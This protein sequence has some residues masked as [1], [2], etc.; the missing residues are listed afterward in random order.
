MKES[1]SAKGRPQLPFYLTITYPSALVS[2]SCYHHQIPVLYSV[3]LTATV[4]STR[5]VVPTCLTRGTST[6]TVCSDVSSDT[7]NS[8][9]EKL[10]KPWTCPSSL[11]PR[12]EGR[13]RIRREMPTA[14]E[15][16]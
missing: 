16:H 6:V 10:M 8:G 12:D 4:A 13:N 5:P 15:T 11:W 1:A 7:V 9:K 14:E 2:D 3:R